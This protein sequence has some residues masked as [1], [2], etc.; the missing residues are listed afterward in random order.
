MVNRR[1]LLWLGAVLAIAGF[2]ALGR[3]QLQRA[4]TKQRM[5]DSAGAVLR[6]RRAL[7]LSTAE[8]S[9]AREYAW[10]SGHGRLRPVPVLLLDNQRRG[11]TVGVREFRVFQPEGGRALLVDLGWLALP[12]RNS[13][14]LPT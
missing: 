4:D 5:L 11:P 2:C 10:V 13:Q 3:W 7:P 9:Q 1:L 8:S 12:G 14:A 6:E